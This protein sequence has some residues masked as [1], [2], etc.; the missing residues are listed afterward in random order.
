MSVAP[1]QLP[2]ADPDRFAIALAHI[3][4]DKSGETERLIAEAL[5]E[6]PSTQTLRFD[7][8]IPTDG[9]DA[10]VTLEEGHRLARRY[11]QESGAQVLI[12][13]TV[14][15][16]NG[17]SVPKLYWTTVPTV[18]L[19]SPAARYRP[20]EDL[21][22]PPVFWN[23]LSDVLRLLVVTQAA[24]FGDAEGQFTANMLRPFAARVQRLVLA[25][26][27]AGSPMLDNSDLKLILAGTLATLGQQEPDVATLQEAE[28]IYREL[29]TAPGEID[30]IERTVILQ[31][32][33]SGVLR[34]LGQR[35]GNHGYIE[36]AL[37]L[38]RS[39]IS[40]TLSR[41]GSDPLFLVS[42]KVDL[43][44]ALVMS[45][46]KSNDRSHLDEAIAVL[47]EAVQNEDSS[48]TPFLWATNHHELGTALRSLGLLKQSA[49]SLREAATEFELALSQY[50][51]AVTPIYWAGTKYN[52]A[53]TLLDLGELEGDKAAIEKA[54]RAFRETLEVRTRDRDSIG[55]AQ[56]EDS[57][58]SALRELSRYEGGVTALEEA[59][60]AARRVLEVRTRERN[61]L[62]WANS[63]YNL[64]VTLLELGRRE[65]GAEHLTESV[66]AF[67]SASNEFGSV[68]TSGLW[69]RAQAQAGTALRIVGQRTG[70][71]SL[72]CQ[73]LSRHVAALNSARQF[74]QSPD[75]QPIENAIQV[76]MLVLIERFGSSCPEICGVVCRTEALALH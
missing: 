74:S 29:L 3:E 52:L 30:Q 9:S 33:L 7:R 31:A 38:Y 57:L 56:S 75:V 23:D 35:T 76:D 53:N 28:R 14:I 17:A 60:I 10:D 61:A 50:D 40:A 51:R 64:G 54:V 44:E 18:P 20:T 22:L 65:Q 12:W 42:L 55:W 49:E 4:H 73:A 66:V 16:S 26:S 2:K 48:R 13:G 43:G 25:P 46:E 36:E 68:S 11:L 19:R 67:D 5:R 24:E 62:R 63:M 39:A 6:F 27:K 58:S 72:F 15:T 59:V 32:N 34:T 70:D 41:H 47:R 37:S 8:T 45:W 69:L 21:S 71:A 1:P